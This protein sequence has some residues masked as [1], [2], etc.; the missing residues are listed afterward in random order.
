MRARFGVGED[1]SLPEVTGE[2]P[3]IEVAADFTGI[4]KNFNVEGVGIG[5]NGEDLSLPKY[6]SAKMWEANLARE[7][8]SLEAGRGVTA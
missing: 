2:K 7:H 6:Q 8:N 5:E 3:S 1:E 4:Y